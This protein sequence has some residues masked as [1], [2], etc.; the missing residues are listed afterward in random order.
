ML[1]T[2]EGLW[3]LFGL[4]IGAGISFTLFLTEPANRGWKTFMFL[5]GIAMFIGAMWLIADW[6]GPAGGGG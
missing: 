1:W 2:L 5:P 6:S 3:L 4:G